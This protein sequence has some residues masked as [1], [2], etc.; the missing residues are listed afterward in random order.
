MIAI[1]EIYVKKNFLASL[2][3]CAHSQGVKRERCEV[4]SG[5]R[6][7][8]GEISLLLASRQGQGKAKWY[9]GQE[10]HGRHGCLDSVAI[11]NLSEQRGSHSSHGNS[12]PEG[13]P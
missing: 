11:R 4:Q 2:S 9:Y 3:G 12:Q 8:V 10:Y 5:N 6:S 13:N 1:F 7:G